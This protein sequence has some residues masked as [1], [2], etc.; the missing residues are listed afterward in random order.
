MLNYRNDGGGLRL[1]VVSNPTPLNYK[2]NANEKKNFNW[3]ANFRRTANDFIFSEKTIEDIIAKAESTPAK[4]D[5][6]YYERAWKMMMA[7]I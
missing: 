1:H 6:I 3:K 2:G 7:I 4:A 5:L